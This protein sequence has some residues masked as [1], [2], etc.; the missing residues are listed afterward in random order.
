MMLF[1]TISQMGKRG[2]QSQIVGT[3]G[4]NNIGRTQKVSLARA[5][6][7]NDVDNFFGTIQTKYAPEETTVNSTY[8]YCKSMKWFSMVRPQV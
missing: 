7:Q 4:K 2:T 5:E 6:D 3:G 8:R 1:H